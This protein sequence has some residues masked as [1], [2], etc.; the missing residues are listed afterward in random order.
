MKALF[1]TL[2]L[3]FS[4]SSFAGDCQDKSI[5]FEG[6]TLN[7][8]LFKSGTCDD[9]KFTRNADKIVFGE[10]CELCA[11]NYS[12]N[13]CKEART[14]ILANMN[15]SGSQEVTVSIPQVVIQALKAQSRCL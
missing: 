15:E 14:N 1:I 3:L 6:E 9:V 5:I 12:E 2:G 13:F 7:F 8:Q 11:G 4:V 10:N